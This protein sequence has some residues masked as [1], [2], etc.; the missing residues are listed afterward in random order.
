MGDL[1]NPLLLLRVVIDCVLGWR[2][3]SLFIS[4][5]LSL[6]RHFYHS[7]HMQPQTTHPTNQPTNRPTNRRTNQPFFLQSIDMNLICCSTNIQNFFLLPPRTHLLPSSPPHFIIQTQ[8][9]SPT[10]RQAT[11]SSSWWCLYLPQFIVVV[12]VSHTHSFIFRQLWSIFFNLVMREYKIRI[13][14]T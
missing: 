12:V 5:S 3:L 11:Q 1:F 4:L 2:F 10:S 7:F 8:P 6:S 9:N 13:F 14:D